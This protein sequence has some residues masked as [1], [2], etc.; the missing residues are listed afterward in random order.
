MMKWRV[1][2]AIV[3][4]LAW[5]GITYLYIDY[6]LETPKRDK[7]IYVSIPKNTSIHEIGKILKENRIINQEWFFALYMK[8]KGYEVKAGEY[9][10]KPAE[11]L[12]DILKRLAEGKQGG[13][14][15]IIPP[16]KNVNNI[17]EI[18]EKNGLDG[19]GFAKALKNRQPK[20][21]FEKQIPNEFRRY[22]RYEGYL[23]PGTYFFKPGEKP[24]KMV[25]EMLKEFDK[26]IKL[27]PTEFEGKSKFQGLP[28]SIDQM[29]IVASLIE[30]EGQNKEELKKIA[31]VIYNRL[32]KPNDPNFKHL[33]IDA[34]NVFANEMEGNIYKTVSEMN[35]KL[36]S[37][38]NT[39]IIE[40]LPPGAI[41]NPS[42]EAMEAAIYPEEHDYYYY[43]ARLDGS[44][45]H[46]FSKTYKEHQKYIQQSIKNANKK[47][48]ESD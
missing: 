37:P 43:T 29:V 17:I 31:G 40:G 10:I 38:Y 21:E 3:L 45:L 32:N 2:H 4:I 19:Q 7:E 35:K 47:R 8:W 1:L 44:G 27:Y 25:D 42:A 14:K 11:K 18:L 15:I 9:Q 6:S 12:P 28:F 22:Y 13:I 48:E 36:D 30:R 46:Y 34:T 16:G 23:F 26:F 39:Y 24:E 5:I 41:A 20:Y 33:R